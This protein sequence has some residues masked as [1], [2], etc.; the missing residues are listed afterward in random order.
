MQAKAET[1]SATE[2]KAML[3]AAHVV[4]IGILRAIEEMFTRLETEWRP[5]K[6]AFGRM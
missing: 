5:S 3:G 2:L 6:R 1:P 4:W